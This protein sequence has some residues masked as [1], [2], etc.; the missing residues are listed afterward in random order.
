MTPSD[1]AN[2]YARKAISADALS[3]LFQAIAG[4]RNLRAATAMLTCFALSVLIPGLLWVVFGKGAVAAALGV[5]TAA[6]LIASGMHAGG[7]LLMDQA[8]Q[9][10]M[11][12]IT[13]AIILGMWCVPKF[14]VLCIALV[15]AAV[16]VYVFLAL[17][18]FICKMPWL[19]P[20][21]YAF[22]FPLSV[23]VAGLTFTAL[24]MGSM[25]AL[26]AIWDGATVGEAFV[27]A[28]AVL[29]AR[30]VET[31]LMS[32]VV[33]VL[34]GF[35]FFLVGGVLFSGFLPAVGLSA[36]VVGASPN[37]FASIGDSLMG[38]G[39]RGAGS[40]YLM[41][42]G[43][44]SGLLFALT[45]TLVFQVW[46][47][48][49]NMMY[50]RVTNGLDASATERALQSGLAE[51]RRRA[52]DIGNKAKEAAE[53]ARAQAAQAVERSRAA[54]VAPVRGDTSLEATAGSDATPGAVSAD[55]RPGPSATPVCPA[56]S[57]VVSPDDYFC[58]ACG[59]RLKA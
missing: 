12:S 4:L 34:A 26:A 24:T 21:L 33:A 6:F 35:V 58:G 18:F 43:L 8:R 10:P 49:I 59:H 29:R 41:A 54:Q 9:V 32:F 38:M 37:M 14:I 36:S 16:V 52:A 57:T 2:R 19:G 7:L 22:V 31:V 46:L 5:L 25:I 28:L 45:M 30:L 56:C 39:G 55:D 47:L 53:K 51:A 48:G 15:L 44:G 42:S 23:V 50:L 1:E 20:I 11:R 3:S 13:D 40:G 27:K 17:L